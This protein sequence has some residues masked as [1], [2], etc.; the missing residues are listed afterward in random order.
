[1]IIEQ[2]TKLNNIQ[3]HLLKMFS[4]PIEEEMLNDVKSLL[5]DYFFDKVVSGADLEWEKRKYNNEVIDEWIFQE[6]Q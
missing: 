2:E 6:H 5:S 1:M 4:L 3:L